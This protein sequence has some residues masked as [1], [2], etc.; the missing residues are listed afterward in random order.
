MPE[1]ALPTKVS[2]QIIKCLVATWRGYF[3]AIKEWSK[4]PGKFLGKPK[5]PK[6]KNKTQGRNVVIYSCI[7]SLQSPSK[8]WYLSLINE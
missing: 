7:I 4:H 6:Y 2:K 8:R 5:I 1:R 3:Q